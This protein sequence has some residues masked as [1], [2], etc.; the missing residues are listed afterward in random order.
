MRQQN[1]NRL[2]HGAGKMSDAG[3]GRDDKIKHRHERGR[4][5]EVFVPA[6][7]V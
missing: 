6:R 3:I 5:C 1:P 4:F 2:T 7:S